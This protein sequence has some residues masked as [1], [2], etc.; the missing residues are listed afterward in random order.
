MKKNLYTERQ[1][2]KV[3]ALNIV[4]QTNE[5]GKYTKEALLYQ[6]II[7]YFH[8]TG[9]S[10][11]KFTDIGR[12]LIENNKEF[13][14]EYDRD[15]RFS[16]KQNT[17]IRYALEKRKDRI[18]NKIKDLVQL[19]LLDNT[20]KTRASKIGTP[21]PL[22]ALTGE[23]YFIHLL[24]ERQKPDKGDVIN[25]DLYDLIQYNLGRFD[26]LRAS[27]L[28]K[29]YEGLKDRG[30]FIE[31]IDVL[32]SVLLTENKMQTIFECIIKT[33]ALIPPHKIANKSL[34][35][36]YYEVNKAVVNKL[37]EET[38]SKYYFSLKLALERE[39]A[40]QH[41]SREWENL[42]IENIGDHSALVLYGR[43]KS[44]KEEYPVLV[45]GPEYWWG[46][47]LGDCSKCNGKRTLTVSDKI[48]GRPIRL[49][50]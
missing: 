45:D 25:S 26:F 28:S 31:A 22:Y 12:W 44:C 11:S 29:I 20:E 5:D 42:M 19:G 2:G 32:E 3:L 33:G 39:I 9:E 36:E 50:M 27:I 41:P 35:W 23:G 49:T 21:I 18:N 13:R 7:Q 48:S 14:H 24:L 34:F 17:T 47:S 16:S 43:C 8:K 38:R 10:K 46:D 6:D 40:L 37:D 15:L 30:S 4:F 1:T